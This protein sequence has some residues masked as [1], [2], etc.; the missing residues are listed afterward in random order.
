MRREEGPKGCSQ[1]SLNKEIRDGFTMRAGTAK[2]TRGK[3][4]TQRLNTLISGYCLM[5]KSPNKT[6]HFWV[7]P[8]IPNI[9]PPVDR[10]MRSPRRFP[11]TRNREGIHQDEVASEVCPHKPQKDSP[12]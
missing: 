2:T 4:K 12:A 8:F 10:R 7:Y 5:H 3:P 6:C 11:C 1:L 9:F